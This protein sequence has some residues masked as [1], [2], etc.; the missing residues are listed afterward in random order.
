[1]NLYNAGFDEQ[2]VKS[3]SGHRSTAVESYKR[4]S[5][6]MKQSVSDSLQP[7]KPKKHASA[8]STSSSSSTS[9]STS[10]NNI[11]ANMDT[12]KALYTTAKECGSKQITIESDG[13]IKINID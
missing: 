1:M 12:L 6:T 5:Q 10:N 9:T 4:P 11:P 8:S 3:R 7:P 2:A 13:T